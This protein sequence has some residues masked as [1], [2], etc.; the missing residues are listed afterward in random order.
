MVLC[1]GS[2]LT[3]CSAEVETIVKVVGEVVPNLEDVSQM[4]FVISSNGLFQCFGLFMND[5]V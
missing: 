2:I 1:F 4:S 5:F 3:V